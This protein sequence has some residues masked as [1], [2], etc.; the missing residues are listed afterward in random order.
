MKRSFYRLR[1]PALLCA[2]IL[3]ISGAASARSLAADDDPIALTD[4]AQTVA[5]DAIAAV[6]RDDMTDGEKLLALHDWLDLHT[7]YI[8]SL[9]GDMAAAVLT[10]G[11]G[12][13]HGYAAALCALCRAAGLE[14]EKVYSADMDHAWA[15]VTLDGAAYHADATWDDGSEGGIGRI[16]HKYCLMDDGLAAMRS[17]YNWDP[18]LTAPGGSYTAAPWLEAVTRVV[19][20]D[21]FLYYLDDSF[22][23][24]RCSRSDWSCEVL[25]TM[26]DRWPIWGGAGYR[27]GVYSG[28]VWMEDRLWFSTP[29]RV[30][31]CTLTGEDLR[32][33][34]TADT[35]DGVLYGLDARDGTLVVCRATEPRSSSAVLLDTGIDARLAWGYTDSLPDL[36]VWNTL[37]YATLGADRLY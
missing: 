32:T 11:C 34:Y 23:L 30:C 4:E 7:Q 33:E 3:L 9:R 6:L 1:L 29:E 35:T 10:E 5:N 26:P 2:G 37:I 20:T 18:A 21:D 22:R 28:L 19:F 14:A 15:V 31:S 25:L 8:H 27:D 16:D 12:Y 17:H 13:C 24:I 36:G